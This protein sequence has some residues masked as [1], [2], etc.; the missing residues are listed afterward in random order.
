MRKTSCTSIQL[1]KILT[2]MILLLPLVGCSKKE[3]RN[4][5]LFLEQVVQDYRGSLRWKKI[6][7][8]I[9]HHRYEDTSKRYKYNKSKL[10]NIVTTKVEI[11]PIFVNVEKNEALV[12][13]EIEYYYKDR[14]TVKKVSIEQRWW[15]HEES[16]KWFIDE[17]FPIPI[18]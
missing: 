11:T 10:Q 6:A 1:L 7:K 18:Y 14:P 3:D 2:I 16:N 15:F 9:T 5:N 17:A 12:L 13:A 4:K 8:A